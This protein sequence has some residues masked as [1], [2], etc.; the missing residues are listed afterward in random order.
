MIQ[1]T[2]VGGGNQ[3]QSIAMLV[4]ELVVQERR[5]GGGREDEGRVGLPTQPAVC[6]TESEESEFD[7][8]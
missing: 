1:K 7:A 6:G 2:G 3:I 5:K 4:V 8:R